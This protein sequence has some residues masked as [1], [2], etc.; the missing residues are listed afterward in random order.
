MFV[1]V[2]VFVES[3]T[4]GAVEVTLPILC[5]P[6]LAGNSRGP[7]GTLMFSRRVLLLR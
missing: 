7:L 4:E 1:F 6:G 5:L 2:F 3:A